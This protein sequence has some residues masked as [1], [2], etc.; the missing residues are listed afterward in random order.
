MRS[1]QIHFF[2]NTGQSLSWRSSPGQDGGGPVDMRW[3]AGRHRRGREADGEHCSKVHCQQWQW[4]ELRSRAS[5]T[6]CGVHSPRSRRLAAILLS[7]G[8]SAWQ[9]IPSRCTKQAADLTHTGTVPLRHSMRISVAARTRGWRKKKDAEGGF[10]RRQ[11]SVMGAG[12]S[13]PMKSES[14][15]GSPRRRQWR[16]TSPE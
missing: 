8:R 10:S 15:E 3:V 6:A 13:N 9:T 16:E 1:L 12:P 11:E 14:L 4:T 7:S 5:M 2:V